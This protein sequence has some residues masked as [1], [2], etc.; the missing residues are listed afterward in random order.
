MEEEKKEEVKEEEE[1]RIN[2]VGEVK[3]RCGEKKELRTSRKRFLEKERSHERMHIWTHCEAM[4]KKLMYLVGK[5][6]DSMLRQGNSKYIQYADPLESE[7]F[8]QQGI[9]MCQKA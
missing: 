6:F 7:K 3:E 8:W 4:E 9:L 5:D 1:E 2:E